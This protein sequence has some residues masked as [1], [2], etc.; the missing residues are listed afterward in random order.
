SLSS[1]ADQNQKAEIFELNNGTVQL[2]VTNLGCT[3]TSFSVPG[4][5]GV[6]SDVVLGLDS[7]E[8]YQV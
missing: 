3:I 4:K 1:M 5:D 2:L 6:L 8:S 7:V